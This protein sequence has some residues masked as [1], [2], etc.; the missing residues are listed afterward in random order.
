[1]GKEEEVPIWGKRIGVGRNMAA[2]VKGR[3]FDEEPEAQ[4]VAFIYVYVGK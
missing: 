3:V 1:M 2:K 4:K